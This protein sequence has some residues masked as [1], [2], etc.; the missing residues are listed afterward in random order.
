[1]FTGI[2][3]IIGTVQDY[4]SLDP[5][6]SGGNGAS[7]TICGAREI[8]GDCHLGDSIA[9]NGV[10]LTVTDF[11]QD[12]F[13][14]GVAPETLRRSNLGELKAND[15]VNLERA[16]S[17]EVRFGGHFVQGHVDSTGEIIAMQPDEN[18]LNV[19]IKVKDAGLLRYIVEKGY[20]TLDGTSLTVTAVDDKLSTLS[21]MLIAYTQHKV[22]LATKKVGSTINIEVDLMGKL[23]EKQ[24]QPMLAKLVESSLNTLVDEAV[25]R[26]LAGN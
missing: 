4:Q 7:L 14:V 12:T 10:C 3:E 19:T 22:I 8:L 26:K 2:V 6:E 15:K 23:V 25:S 1:M 20:I 9:V 24:I 17:G 16:V 11:D 18:A 13:K 21:I 5:T